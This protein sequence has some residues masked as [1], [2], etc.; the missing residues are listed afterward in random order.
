VASVREIWAVDC[1][2]DP[3]EHGCVPAPFLWGAYNGREY[4]EFAETEDLVRFLSA[5]NIIVY[6]HNGGKFDWHFIKHHIAPFSPILII[7]G[8]LAKFK[9]GEAEFRDSYNILPIPLAAY[10]KDEFDYNLM[11]KDVRA[12][13]MPQIRTYL[14][15]DCVYLHEL[16]TKFRVDYGYNLTLAGAAVKYWAKHFNG[17]V[18]RTSQYFFNTFAPFYYGGRVEC[19]KKGIIDTSFNVYDI[20]SAYPHAM[21]H[22]HPAGPEYVAGTVLPEDDADI[23]ASFIELE[24]AARG[25]FPLRPKNEMSFPADGARRTFR[26]TGHEFLSARENGQLTDYTLLKCYTFPG[27]V[28]FTGYVQHFYT[29]RAATAKGSAENIFAKL[30]MNSLYGKYGA[31]PQKYK[32]Y[33]TVPEA[34]EQSAH[35]AGYD[36]ETFLTEDTLIASRPLKEESQRFYNVATAASITGFVRAMMNDALKSVK[37]P[38]YCDTDAIACAEGVGM[39]IHTARLGAWDLEAEC[40][41]GA[42][43]GKKLY[44][45]KTVGGKYKL[46]S[47]GVRLTAAQIYDVARGEEVEFKKDSPTFGIKGCKFISRRVKMKN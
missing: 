9:I 31:N 40:T 38:L 24:C 45:F 44:A 12:G 21:T 47:K 13:H 23:R 20:N 34:L 36:I 28:N 7:A 27:R 37:E 19:F 3:F 25:A 41:G 42:V 32:E 22:D 17:P 30:L 11:R 1:E 15:N 26:V 43:A 14:R 4:H 33:M 5:K 18:E 46:A 10:K 6:A 35:E 2:T 16:V 29:L 8:R 39:D